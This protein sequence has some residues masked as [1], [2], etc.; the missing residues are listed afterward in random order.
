M[1]TLVT[2]NATI[3]VSRRAAGQLDFGDDISKIYLRSSD[4]EMVS[5]ANLVKPGAKPGRRGH[6]TS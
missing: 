6:F 1:M 3:Y 2:E 5:L 4:G